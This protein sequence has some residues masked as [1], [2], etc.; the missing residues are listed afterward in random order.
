MSVA[1]SGSR[2][3]TSVAVIPE[4]STCPPWPIARSR[5]TRLRAGPKKSPPRAWALPLWMAIRARTTAS[6]GHP[7]ADSARCPSS[8]AA[9]AANGS[10][11]RASTPSPVV[12]TTLPPCDSTATRRIVSCASSATCIEP[13]RPPRGA[14]SLRCPSSGRSPRRPSRWSLGSATR[15]HRA[16]SRGYRASSGRRCQVGPLEQRQVS[17]PRA[18]SRHSRSPRPR[19][20]RPS[21]R[22][23]RG[24]RPSRA[25]RSHP[26]RPLAPRPG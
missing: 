11:K 4:S 12:L 6:V 16:M 9:T 8:A 19:G 7:C 17:P 14:S 3:A 26:P 21:A 2:S 25:V 1:P 18:A 24:R 15:G 22:R 10:S 13:M 20:G 5:A 23:S